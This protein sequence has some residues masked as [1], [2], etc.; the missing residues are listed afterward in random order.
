MIFEIGQIFEGTY[1]PEAA[2]WCNENRASMVEMTPVLQKQERKVLTAEAVLDEEGREL[3]PARYETVVEE[4]A[5]R[6]FQ[7]VA[8]PEP[9][10][11]ERA[12]ILLDSLT[13][14]IQNALD[15]FARTR[16]YDD[17]RSACTYAFS[18]DA[19]FRAEG[20]YCMALRD[21]T[22]REAWN[23][24]DDVKAGGRA[25][26]SEAEVLALLPVGSAAWPE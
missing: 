10:A 4:V 18:A 23:L 12:A 7:I 1:P 8:I 25:I 2:L 22:W 5:V 11:E 26:P 19:A 3:E 9:S 16:G 14:A 6:R 20:E 24:L 17:I 21:A 13:N 15:D